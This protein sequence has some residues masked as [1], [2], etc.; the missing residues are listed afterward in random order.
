M[1][2]FVV[3]F[4]SRLK[5]PEVKKAKCSNKIV[6][7]YDLEYDKNHIVK[8]VKKG[9]ENIYNKI[10]TYKNDCDFSRILKTI[11]MTGDITLY[12][13]KA[14][15]DMDLTNMPNSMAEAKKAVEKAAILGESVAKSDYFKSKGIKFADF[16]KNFNEADYFEYL[17]NKYSKKE[18]SK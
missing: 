5:E 8:V 14:V 3:K 7:I 11:E 13:N 9:E 12:Q 17:K 18:E 2:V 1:E 4:K 10:Q 6:T 16:V 15:S